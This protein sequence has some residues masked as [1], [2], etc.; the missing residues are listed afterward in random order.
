[1]PR[2]PYRQIGVSL[3]RDFRNDQ[4][5]N[6]KDIESDIKEQKAR[7]DA[8]ISSVEQPSEVVD[9]RVDTS[10]T[11][12]A[13]LKDRLD[14][15]DQN[16]ASQLADLAQSKTDKIT[17]DADRAYFENK[18]A[19]ILDGS[20]DGVFTTLSDLQS[21]YPDGSQGLYVVQEDGNWYFWL[22]GSGWTAGGL[23]QSIRLANGS[24]S[25]DAISVKTNTILSFDTNGKLSTVS[26]TDEQGTTRT[27]T[28]SYNEIGQLV[29][30]QETGGDRSINRTL[31]YN[32]DGVLESVTASTIK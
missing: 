17:S 3:N 31:N 4:N 27:S 16:T 9:A 30:V 18:F 24:V 26:E 32:D 6:L 13:T 2:Y 11:E 21:A 1:M 28:L 23:Y 8:Q 25:D 10:G 19:S 20:P 7:V 29:N 14:S 22:D 15:V 5:Q 12:H